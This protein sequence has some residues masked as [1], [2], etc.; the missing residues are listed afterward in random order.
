ME[1]K[2]ANRIRI[3]ELIEQGKTKK[4]ITDALQISA[5][6]LATNLTY[7]RLM[8]LFPVVR[9]DG[10]MKFISAE[11]NAELQAAKA[12]SKKASA[13]PRSKMTPAKRA[14]VAVAKCAKAQA[15][16]KTLSEVDADDDV[17]LMYLERAKIEAKITAYELE[18]ATREAASCVIDDE[19]KEPTDSEESEEAVAE[20]EDELI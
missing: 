14:Q 1:A 2:V 16:L 15:E 7:L 8:G 17:H 4:E 3:K 12:Q 6:S 5:A 20:E 11:E 18:V 9:D 10:R 19:L 13:K